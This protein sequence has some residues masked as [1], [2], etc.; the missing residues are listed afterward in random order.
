MKHA[1]IA[2]LILTASAA[3]AQS[4]CGPH[5]DVVARLA[6]QYGEALVA[7]GLIN[8]QFIMQ[9]FAN[10]ETGSWTIVA[11]GVTGQTCLIAAGTMFERITPAEVK[12]G[13]E[14]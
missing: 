3:N 13:K 14:G 9:T 7:H 2:A 11:V 12:K 10:L 8:D 6:E 5:V 4:N 1:T